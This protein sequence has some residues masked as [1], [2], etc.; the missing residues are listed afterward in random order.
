[1]AS[2]GPRGLPSRARYT[3]ESPLTSLPQWEEEG[4]SGRTGAS[5][6]PG[7]QS[8]PLPLPEVPPTLLPCGTQSPSPPPPASPWPR[9]LLWGRPVGPQEDMKD[10]AIYSAPSACLLKR[11]AQQRSHLESFFSKDINT[12]NLVCL[13]LAVLG[14]RC[15]VGFSLAVDSGV[16]LVLR[17]WAPHGAGSSP[18]EHRLQGTQASVA[19]ACGLSRGACGHMLWGTCCGAYVVGHMG[20]Q[21]WGT[22]A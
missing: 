5:W 4:L 2:S 3:N 18:A 21:S 16:T 1:M 17:R 20:T 11:N 22:R 12:I 10:R 14:L 13:V 19:V 15:C 6:L 7:D 9:Q 8:P